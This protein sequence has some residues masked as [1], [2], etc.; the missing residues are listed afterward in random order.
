[1]DATQTENEVRDRVAGYLSWKIIP[2]MA[3]TVAVLYGLVSYVS[4]GEAMAQ[5]MKGA[6]WEW[7]V[8]VVVLLGLNL[9]FNG[10][11]FQVVL[12]AAGHDIGLKRS[13]SVVLSVWPLVLVIPARINDLLRA[14]A[15]ADEVPKADCLGSVV[16]ERFV[17]VQTLCVL[18]MIGGIGLG[19]WPVVGVLATMWIGGWSVVLVGLRSVDWVVSLPV[20]RRKEKTLRALLVGFRSLVEKPKLLVAIIGV[21]TLAWS[22]A[23]GNLWVLGQLFGAGLSAGVILALWPLALFAGMVPL[24]MGG[25]GTRDGAFLALQAAVGVEVASESALLAATF[26]YGLM[27]VL[28]PGVIGIP[29]MMRWL[30]RPKD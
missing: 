17:D 1:M 21:S 5:A 16:A 9:V 10:W 2:V 27:L 15:L 4:D 11:R 3:L 14:W 25:M 29:W 30:L 24:T 6:R 26:G 12:K 22:T 8:V 23:M 7:S 20:V 18:G 19:A 28:L 13:L